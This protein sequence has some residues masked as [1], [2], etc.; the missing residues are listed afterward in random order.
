M[1]L[2]S[3]LFPAWAIIIPIWFCLFLLLLLKIPGAIPI[4][5]ATLILTGLFS[6]PLLALLATAIAEDDKIVISKDGIAFP[7]LF[8]PQLR[9]RREFNWKDM[10]TVHVN[11]AGAA[12][13]GAKDALTLFFSNGGYA[14][15]SLTKLPKQDLEQLVFAL[16][17]FGTGRGDEEH[18]LQLQMH[19]RGG[20]SEA[21]RLSITTLWEEEL[22]SRFAPTTFAPLK[23]GSSLQSGRLKIV[24]QLA[25]GGFSATYLAQRNERD[26]VVVKE[27]VDHNST[28][29]SVAHSA[30]EILKDEAS[31]L[32]ALKHPCIA[33][34]YDHFVENNRQYLLMQYVSGQDLRRLV[35][36]RGAQPEASVINWAID[37]CQILEYLHEQTP[38]II[39]MDLT[40]EN[41]ML[42]YDGQIFLIDFGSAKHH[43]PTGASQLSGKQGYIAPEQIQLKPNPQSDIFAL[44]GTIYYLLTGRDPD[45]ASDSDLSVPT[46]VSPKLARLLKECQLTDLDKRIDSASILKARLKELALCQPEITNSNGQ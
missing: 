5:P 35:M 8:L 42:R 21:K 45:L 39:H 26:L 44:G 29:S 41:L 7:L 15:L 33:R 32:L 38:P 24:K 30:S 2:S 46:F 19:L 6:T 36:E 13:L 17:Q 43:G 12:T 31:I 1:L 4:L 25:F 9:F 27:A 10:T 22:A 20:E 23:A 18:L 16:N 37:I 34:V 14:R 11:W 40:P 28:E 3:I